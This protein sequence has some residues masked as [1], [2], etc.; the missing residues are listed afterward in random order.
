M[1]TL[2]VSKGKCLITQ[3][4]QPIQYFFLVHL[5]HLRMLFQ[6]GDFV[7]PLEAFF[8]LDVHYLPKVVTVCH[9]LVH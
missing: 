4:T 5:L 7:N 2:L 8:N 3:L 6:G 1:D 9:Q